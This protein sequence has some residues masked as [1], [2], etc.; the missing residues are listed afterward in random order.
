MLSVWAAAAAEYQAAHPGV[1]INITPLENEAFKAKLTTVTQAG[2]P[3]D[4]FHT[5]A[6]VCSS[7]QRDAGLVQDLSTS[8]ASW[9]TGTTHVGRGAAVRHRLQ[10]LRDSVRTSAWWASGTTRNCSPG[11]A[12]PAA[13]GHLDR[14]A[15]RG[16]GLEVGPGSS[17][18]RWPA[19][20]SGPALLLGRTSPCASAACPP[21][22]RPRWTDPSTADFRRRRDAAG[23]AGQAR[24]VSRRGSW[25]P[26]T[27]LRTARR[28][29]WATAGAAMELMG[30]WP[31]AVTGLF[32]YQQEGPW[33]QA[34]LSSR[35]RR[36]DGGKG[37]AGDAFGGGGGFAIRA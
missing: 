20:T 4:I 31:P 6:V 34:R 13:S 24:S 8:C 26:R 30:Q 5:W 22:G 1:K 3:P 9:A 36:V 37:R 15:H 29:R 27:P 10:D 28:P 35:S 12:S 2:S 17:R 11:P 7:K 21:C 18:S 25:A 16:F 19:R 32:F 23:G 33:R 14:P